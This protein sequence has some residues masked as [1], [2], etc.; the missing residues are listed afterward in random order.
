MPDNT[1]FLPWPGPNPWPTITRPLKAMRDKLRDSPAK[2][3]LAIIDYWVG[4]LFD[5]RARIEK[6]RFPKD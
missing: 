5:L 1:D 4:Q 3:R 6:G 2:D